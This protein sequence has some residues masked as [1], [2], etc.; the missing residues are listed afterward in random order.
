MVVSSVV[1]RNV[2][3]KIE[4]NFAGIN[5]LNFLFR[6]TDVTQTKRRVAEKCMRH[7]VLCFKQHISKKIF[8]YP[9]NYLE[10]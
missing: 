1:G 4:G 5:N 10:S 7:F 2:S 8:I 6:P 3:Y 9:C